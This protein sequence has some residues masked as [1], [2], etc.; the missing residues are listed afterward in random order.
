MKNFFRFNVFCAA[1]VF[2][3]LFGCNQADRAAM[4]DAIALLKPTAGNTAEGVVYFSAVENGVRVVAKL[5][6]LAPGPHGFHIHAFGD[7]SAPDG[8][9]A[10]GH[11][12]PD[13]KPHG[14]PSDK[15][16]HMGD[17]GNLIA[18]QNGLAAADFVDPLLTLTGEQSIIGR[19]VIVH[20]QADDLT[21]QPTGAAGGRLV[22]GVI[23]YAQK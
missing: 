1:A 16:R 21:T 13:D 5:S 15:H 6:N 11:F 3:L 23:G 10:G 12:N 20:A 17:L 4:P 7:C 2:A 14:A 22:C 19:G 8:S 9:S 18:D